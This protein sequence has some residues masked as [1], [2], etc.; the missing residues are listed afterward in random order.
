MLHRHSFSKMKHIL[1]T[2]AC[3]CDSSNISNM[4]LQ[5]IL[6][7]SI[8]KCRV[9][10]D[11]HVNSLTHAFVLTSQIHTFADRCPQAG[12]VSLLFSL[13]DESENVLGS[14]QVMLSVNIKSESCLRCF[15]PFLNGSVAFMLL[16]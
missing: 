3:K 6:Q 15:E 12:N 11:V 5:V 14:I 16:K 1:D 7:I 8:T 2:E 13:S 10:S 4:H 9:D